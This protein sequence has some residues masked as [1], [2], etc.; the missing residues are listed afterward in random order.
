[1][2]DALGA[3]PRAPLALRVAPRS[4][5]KSKGGCTAALVA[6]AAFAPLVGCG[7]A[8]TSGASRLPPGAERVHVPP[9]DNHTADADAGALVAGAVRDEL[10]RRGALGGPGSGARLDGEVLEIAFGAADPTGATY[11]VSLVVRAR[12]V[13]GDGPAGPEQRVRREETY[14]AGADQLESEGRRRLALRRLAVELARDLV[15]RLERG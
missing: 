3:A 5:A 11:V 1:M 4:G 15:D 7:Y 8:F 2:T 13:I 10:G 9:F 14:L 12:L 6:L